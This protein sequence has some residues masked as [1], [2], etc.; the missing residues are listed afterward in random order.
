M[1]NKK[2]KAIFFFLIF[3]LLISVFPSPFVNR[4]LAAYED[5][6]NDYTEVDALNRI[7][8]NTNGSQVNITSMKNTDDNLYLVKDLESAHGYEASDWSLSFEI[9][10]PNSNVEGQRGTRLLGAG[11][12]DGLGDVT[13]CGVEYWCGIYITTASPYLNRMR[14]GKSASTG[15]SG[16]VNL[17]ENQWYYAYFNRS[18]TYLNYSL[19]TS[20]TRTDANLVETLTYENVSTDS[21]KYFYAAQSLDIDNYGN[22]QESW[23]MRNYELTVDG[24][25]K[26]DAP[27]N[28]V[29]DYDEAATTINLT[30]TKGNNANNTVVRYKTTGYPTSITDGTLWY[31]GT[32]T[33]YENNSINTGQHYYIRA[34][35]ESNWSNPDGYKIS[36]D[37][38]QFDYGTLTLNCL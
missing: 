6:N 38:L 11:F 7:S 33:Y 37:Y 36:D 23:K 24:C 29:I 27:T 30:W 20:A 28:G 13:A 17:G 14:L 1:K 26:P 31:N 4:V 9:F 22:N 3:T 10:S 34:W 2:Q 35:S 18:D 32:L 15:Q 12:S 5:L 16:T 8:M 19:Y 21:F 25:L